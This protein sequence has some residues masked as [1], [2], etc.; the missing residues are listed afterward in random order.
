[1]PGA[2]TG[3]PADKRSLHKGQEDAS[4]R[5]DRGDNLRRLHVVSSHQL[6]SKT[7]TKAKS[8]PNFCQILVNRATN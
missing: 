4:K 6:K 8:V 5:N 2:G 3:Q 7:L 1:M